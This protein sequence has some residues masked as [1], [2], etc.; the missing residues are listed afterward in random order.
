MVR[1]APA[2]QPLAELAEKPLTP[3]A[4]G[5]THRSAPPYAGTVKALFR[6]SQPQDAG[7]PHRPHDPVYGITTAEEAL[8]A[9]IDRRQRQ[10]LWTMGFRIV[11]IAVVLWVPGLSWPIRVILAIVATVIPFIA[12]VRANGAPLQQDDPT[13]LLLTPPPPPAI[14]GPDHSLDPAEEFLTGESWPAGSR[15]GAADTDSAHSEQGRAEAEHGET[16]LDET[17][18]SADGTGVTSL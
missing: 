6:R 8:S 2:A 4:P 5:L 16:G 7:K 18:L 11:A 10:Y 14:E 12:V 17:D 3:G 1:F 9:D 15:S 13:N